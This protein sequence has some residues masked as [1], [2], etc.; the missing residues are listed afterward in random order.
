[1]PRVVSAR[2]QVVQTGLKE[3]LCCYSGA[4]AHWPLGHTC[5]HR[6]AFCFVFIWGYIGVYNWFRPW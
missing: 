4:W 6:I 5:F 1:M 2:S 3:I